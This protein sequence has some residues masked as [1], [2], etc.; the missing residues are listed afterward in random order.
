[1]HEF[2]LTGSGKV[3]KFRLQEQL[4]AILGLEGAAGQKHA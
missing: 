3:Q 2:P 1:M 4:I